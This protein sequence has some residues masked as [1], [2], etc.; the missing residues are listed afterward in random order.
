MTGVMNDQGFGPAS[1]ALSKSGEFSTF[2]GKSVFDA[3]TSLV[4]AF[5]ALADSISGTEPSLFN[6]KLTG[7]EAAN[8]AITVAHTAGSP[9]TL[10]NHLPNTVQVMLNGQVL[11]SASGP[12]DAGNV[13]GD[14]DYCIIGNGSA[15]QIRFGF[16]LQVDDQIQIWDLA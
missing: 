4:G 6:K 8:A 16:K 9:A 10:A 11:L 1:W 14:G 7:P 2:V 3:N 5:N 15:N 13:N 12:G